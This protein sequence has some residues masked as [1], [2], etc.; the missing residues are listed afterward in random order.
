MKEGRKG[1]REGKEGAHDENLVSSTTKRQNI[2]ILRL[3]IYI[4]LSG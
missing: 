3:F 4:F 1:G 2:P